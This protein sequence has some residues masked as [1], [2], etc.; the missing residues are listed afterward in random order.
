MKWNEDHKNTYREYLQNTS[1]I[2]KLEEM[3]LY[4]ANSD[5]DSHNVNVAVSLFVD[6]LHSAA[7]PFFLKSYNTNG[8]GSSNTNKRPEWANDEWKNKKKQFMRCKNRFKRSPTD[9]NRENM[10]K[11]RSEYKKHTWQS[12]KNHDIDRTSK[13]LKARF[14]NAKLY[15]K[16]LSGH[17]IKKTNNIPSF[18]EFKQS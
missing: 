1:T 5:L 17:K 8:L 18:H 12:K 10:V 15:W 4:I 3:S 16:L 13:L 11:A 9:Y 6:A 14:K 7:D 2:S